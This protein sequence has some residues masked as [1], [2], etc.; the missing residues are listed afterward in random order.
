MKLKALSLFLCTTLLA[1]FAMTAQAD[2]QL[3]R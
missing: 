1:G 3:A 2:V